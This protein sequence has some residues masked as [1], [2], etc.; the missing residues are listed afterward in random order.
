VLSYVVRRLLLMIP[1]LIGISL[2][3]FL[4]IALAPG[5]MAA[6]L[7]L[8]SGGGGSGEPGQRA[9][10]EAYLE[11]R[12]GLND[13]V[14]LQYVRWLGRISPVKFGQRDQN[15]PKGGKVRPPKP[16]DPPPLAGVF[17]AEG[18]VPRPP[19]PEPPELEDTPVALPVGASLDRWTVEPGALVLEGQPVARLRSGAGVPYL[20]A[21]A[22]GF[23][24]IPDAPPADAGG[25]VATISPDLVGAYRRADSDYARA[26]A[27]YTLARVE[28]NRALGAYADAAGIDGAMDR[29]DR[30]IVPRFEAAGLDAS[31]PEAEAVRRSGEAA[32]DAYA[33]AL[34]ER[35]GLVGVFEARPFPEAGVWIV[36]GLLSLD[37]PDLGFS[38]ARSR[39]VSEIIG[40]ALPVTLLLNIVAVPIIYIVAIPMGI[41]AATRRGTWIDI[42]S[43][44]LFIALFSVPVVWAGTLA[45]G[46]LGNQRVLGDW[47][48]P[49]AGLNAA[50]A[51]EM[52]F[53]PAWGPDG[54]ERG[55]LLDTL[56]HMT[57]PVLCL[58]YAGF[59]VL[60][61]QTRAAMLENFNADFVRTAKA[62]GVA[63]RT[64]VFKHVFRNSLLPLITIFATVFPAMLAGSVVIESI[65]S[66][67]GMG[68]E[69]IA[70][71]N[72]RD[73]E[74][75][76]AITVIASTVN[77]LALL[78]AD[79]LYALADPRIAYD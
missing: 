78:L 53:L 41:L 60:S 7:T 6:A 70:A 21:P 10:L 28:L 32:I 4:L 19:P 37:T 43:G 18:A 63:G 68:S 17:Y 3:V 34:R 11:E 30:P 44:V 12:Y 15:D 8:G 77:I 29:K 74:L 56:W 72:L 38:F 40:A 61:K 79:L 13:P 36:P 51:R 35:A 62:K 50:D 48:F 24:Q 20:L 45:V 47:A 16:L 42:A 73:R 59:A 39:P 76:L 52:A 71:I 65:F 2:L 22:R 33:A 27:A 1:T 46:Y 14:L 26:R 69:L 55:F 9:M 64:I 49:A 31:V 25:A 5:G 57:L 23:L 67:P 58:V 66:I 54:F 75:L